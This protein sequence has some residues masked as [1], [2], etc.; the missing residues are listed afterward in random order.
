MILWII[1]SKL[2]PYHWV[3]PTISVYYGGL[4]VEILHTGAESRRHFVLKSGALMGVAG[5]LGSVRALAAARVLETAKVTP[6]E[7]L[8]QEHGV[9]RRLL[10]IYDD[11]AGRLLT[12]DL[13]SKPPARLQVASYLHAFTR[14]YR[15][16]LPGKTP[17]FIRPSGR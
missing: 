9:L 3:Q 2:L 5:L 15:P 7:D 10:L 1:F 8:M 16:P 12:P 17:C 13:F 4:T 11:V 14:M 6:T